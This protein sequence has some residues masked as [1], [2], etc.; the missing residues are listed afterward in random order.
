MKVRKKTSVPNQ[1]VKVS[2]VILLS[3]VDLCLVYGSWHNSWCWKHRQ[4]MSYKCCLISNR[5]FT[6]IGEQITATNRAVILSRCRTMTRRQR[7]FF[8]S[9]GSSCSHSLW[10]YIGV[11]VSWGQHPRQGCRPAT[12]SE[13]NASGCVAFH[14]NTPIFKA[15]VSAGHMTL[16]QSCSPH[17]SRSLGNQGCQQPPQR[18]GCFAFTSSDPERRSK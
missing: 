18:G 13:T 11:V 10:S 8:P 15:L 9:C 7:F 12:G 4:N 17:I 16:C 2:F 6:L 5:F 1:S 14:H 3:Y